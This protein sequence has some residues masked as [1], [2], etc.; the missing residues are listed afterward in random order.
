MA[1]RCSPWSRSTAACLILR[2]AQ[3]TCDMRDR[4]VG[5]GGVEHLHDRR[6]RHCDG[7]S[8]GLCFGLFG[9]APL[10]ARSHPSFSRAVRASLLA[11]YVSN[12]CLPLGTPLSLA[13]N[14][15][16]RNIQRSHRSRYRFS[17]LVTLLP[18]QAM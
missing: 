14:L 18:T 1:T 13:T 7:D 2:G 15:Y 10:I 12:E 11:S 8:P 6:Q 17:S 16:L 9:A 5:N 4:Y 3:S